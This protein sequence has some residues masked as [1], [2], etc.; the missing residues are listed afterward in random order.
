MFIGFAVSGFAAP[1]MI[2]KLYT[3]TNSYVP[4]YYVAMVL[5]FVGILLAFLYKKVEKQS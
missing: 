1:M 4:A 3:S 5:S 2:G